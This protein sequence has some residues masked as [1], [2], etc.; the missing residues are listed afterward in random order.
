MSVVLFM[1]GLVLIVLELFRETMRTTVLL[2]GAAMLG[3]PA[4]MH[5]I[6]VGTPGDRPGPL[7]ALHP[8]DRAWLR[9]HEY[10]SGPDV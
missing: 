9:Y 2:L 1:G 3:L 8:L 4:F 10:L 7:A 6:D 5:Q